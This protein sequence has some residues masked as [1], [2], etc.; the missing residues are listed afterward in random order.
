MIPWLAGLFAEPEPEPEPEPKK[1]NAAG[2]D[3]GNRCS[4]GRGWALRDD[5]DRCWRCIKERPCVN[6]QR[7]ADP[8]KESLW[9]GECT[10]APVH[11]ITYSL[12]RC[13]DC[14]YIATLGPKDVTHSLMGQYSVAP[15]LRKHFAVAPFGNSPNKDRLNRKMNTH[16]TYPT[17]DTARELFPDDPPPR[18]REYRI[19]RGHPRERS[20]LYSKEV[21]VDMKAVPD[22]SPAY[23]R[24][25]VGSWN[26]YGEWVSS[27]KM[28]RSPAKPDAAHTDRP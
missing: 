23:R 20:T 6:D 12:C 19:F 14:G 25:M 13:A 21:R 26:P 8:P 7:V 18:E 17:D 9:T 11:T 4:C 1:Q 22:S 28:K 5:G 2:E 24:P 16:G 3:P 15:T 27:P 10:F